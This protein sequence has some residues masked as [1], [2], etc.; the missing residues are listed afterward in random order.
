M[1]GNRSETSSAACALRP[2]VAMPYWSV[3][4]PSCHG[5][6]ADALLE[7]VPAAERSDPATLGEQRVAAV[8]EQVEE[9]VLVH[10]LLVVA[11]HFDRD[12]L[13]R[14]AGGEG[15]CAGPGNVV[16]VARRGGAVG[17]GE[18]HRHGLIVGGREG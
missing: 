3:F 9:E 16:L 5:Y 13:G 6:I 17:G 8:A 11:L 18:R 12:R 2:R 7:C 14:L 1:S 10:L 4:C 15:Q